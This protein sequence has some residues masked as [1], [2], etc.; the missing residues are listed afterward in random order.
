MF[1]QY[2]VDS[3][4]IL[5]PNIEFYRDFDLQLKLQAKNIQTKFNLFFNE[6]FW[7]QLEQ[8]IVRVRKKLRET[9]NYYESM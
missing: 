9:N 2:K 3:K 7:K 5:R 8:K 6:I 1:Y 4:K